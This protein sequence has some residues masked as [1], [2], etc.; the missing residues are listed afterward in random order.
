MREGELL[1][2]AWPH[3][4][5]TLGTASIQQ[6]FYRWS[7]NKKRGE[8]ARELLKP[9]KTEKS[10]RQVALLPVLVDELR[11]L[12]EEQ[13]ARRKRIGA[14]YDSR[15]FVFCQAEGKPLHTHNVTHR[16][17]VKVLERAKLARIRFH[18]LRH[19]HATLLLQQGVHPKIV[20]ERLGH[21]TIAITLDLYSHTVPGMQGQAASDLQNRHFGASR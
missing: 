11:A 14:A 16:D 13:E 4:D 1:G 7:G 8:A 9:P 20:S 15:D 6:T 21:S 5:L 3:I 12:R 19:G 2:L 10:R 17:F 18:D